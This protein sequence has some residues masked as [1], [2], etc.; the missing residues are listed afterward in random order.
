M[1][2]VFYLS[3][4]TE[5]FSEQ[6]LPEIQSEGVEKIFTEVESKCA[7]NTVITESNIKIR[8]VFKEAVNYCINNKCCLLIMNALDMYLEYDFARTLEKIHPN[9]SAIDFPE[10]NK[11]DIKTLV[12]IAQLET[13]K[14]LSNIAIKVKEASKKGVQ[15]R[16]IKY[17][18]FNKEIYPKIETYRNKG[19]SYEDI[20]Y[21][22]NQEGLKTV[23]GKSF[24]ANGVRTIYQKL[25][26]RF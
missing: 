23:R 15:A 22:L 19:V 7:R 20:A 25:K 2:V 21:K 6:A 12:K 9:V 10:I 5:T 4:K 11:I 1:S 16:K 26:P 13:A 18:T 8:T 3:I 14:G 17:D 24:T